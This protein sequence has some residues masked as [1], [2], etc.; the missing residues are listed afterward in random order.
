MSMYVMY[1]MY[2]MYVLNEVKVVLIKYSTT[3]I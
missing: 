3:Y 1:M 2:Y